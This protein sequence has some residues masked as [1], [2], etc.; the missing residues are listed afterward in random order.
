[1]TEADESV[2]GTDPYNATS[3]FTVGSMQTM[4]SQVTLTWSI[5]AG[6]T[7]RVQSSNDLST[8]NNVS[9]CETTATSTTSTRTIAVMPGERQFYRVM[10]VVP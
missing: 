9:G 10:V 3:R 7:Y 2:G 5:V 6:K 1:M 4:G 8:W